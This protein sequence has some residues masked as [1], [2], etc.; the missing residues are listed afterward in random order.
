MTLQVRGLEFGYAQ[1]EVL[2]GIDLVVEKAELL[3]ILGP[4]GVGKTTLLR[5]INAMLTP[6]QGV[7]MVENADIFSLSAQE[8]ARNIAYVAQR[9][10]SGRM[11]AFD[12][13]LLGRKPH[14]GWRVSTN[15]VHHAEAALH[16]VGMDHLALRSINQMSG[17]ELQKVC[18]ARAIAQAP[19]VLLLDEPT[20]A[21]DLRNK[22]DILQTIQ[23]IVREQQMAA[24]M[25]MH[26][27]NS[28]LRFAHKLLFIKNGKVRTLCRPDE[29]QPAMIQD[30][31]GV[32][33]E[34]LRHGERTLVVPH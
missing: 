12:A 14:L 20:S 4:N 8:I 27:L 3:A 13:V 28:A 34:I 16:C 26:D 30:V 11:T 25:T 19:R 33:V 21:L 24:V 2:A 7:V 15:D 22:L 29:V 1:S 31:Y 23:R 5:C 17:G 9:A 32:E 6:R 10:D 18:I